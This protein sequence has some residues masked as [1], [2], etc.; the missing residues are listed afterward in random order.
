MTQNSRT[1]KKASSP[2]A[3]A[4]E[5]DKKLGRLGHVASFILVNGLVVAVIAFIVLH[6]LMQSLAQEEARNM[7]RDIL[8]ATEQSLSENEKTVHSLEYLYA[9]INPGNEEE[10][11]ALTDRVQKLLT[12][13]SAI[14]GVLW[15]TDRGIWRQENVRG[16]AAHRTSY[17][18][19]YGWPDFPSLNKQ[20]GEAPDNQITY[21]QD[22]PWP[23]MQGKVTSAANTPVGLAIRSHLQDGSIGILLVVTTP[24]KIFGNAWTIQREDIASVMIQDRDTGFILVN[25]LLGKEAPPADGAAP[26]PAPQAEEDS[27]LLSALG[28]GNAPEKVNY[29][30]QLGDQF[31]NIAFGVRPTTVSRFLGMAPLVAA[32]LI[33]LLTA[34][35]AIVAQRKYRQ[36]MML[37]EMSK[38]L[39]GAHSELQSRISERDKLFHALRKSEREYRAVINSVSDV[40]FETDETGRL[41]F[42]NET[43][44]KMTHR[45]VAETIGQSL[46]A[47]FEQGE[48]N[49][50]R[51][52]FE[53]LVRGERQAY[54]SETQLNLG[55]GSLKPV[56]VAFSMLRMTEDKS[57]R[58]V[59]TITDIEKRRRAEQAVRAA[60]QRYR[61]IF[62]NSVSGL[63]QID[64]EGR[65]ISA[66]YALAEV[67]GYGSPDELIANVTDIGGQI[68]ANR[69][70]H[71]D[72]VQRLLFEGRVSGNEVE[73]T[74]RDGARR[75]VLQNARTVRN[76]TGK[77]DYYEGSLWDVT[78]RREADE[79][80]RNARIQAEISSRTRMEFLANMSHE[81]RTPL[82]AVIGF[83]E[84]IKDEVMGPLEIQVYKE[85]AQDIYDSGNY[86]LKIISE[87]LEVS[88]IETGNR[89][90]NIS[91]FRLEKALKSCVTIMNSRIE[92][93]GVELK[94][95]IPQE[96]PEL[97]AEELGIKQVMLNLIGNAIKFTPEGGHVKVSAGLNDDGGMTIDIVDDGIGMSEEEIKKAMQ[98]FGKVDTT[99]SGM[100]EGTGLGLTIVESLVRLH[101]GQF[102]IISQKG[103]GT[104]AR[105]ILPA[106][107]LLRDEGPPEVSTL[108]TAEDAPEGE[109]S[110]DPERGAADPLAA[111][112]TSGT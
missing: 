101:G 80:M 47:M 106:S 79:A 4:A 65:F 36:D 56:E 49:K 53:E 39:E 70:D 100:K 73:I 78:E 86:L 95:D 35:S 2:Q 17:D 67:L 103:L 41:M 107:R 26:V 34:L 71:K 7:T 37:A 88:K 46:F 109:E 27:P 3:I 1:P 62:E 59:G 63:Y 58:V 84:I 20:M 33:L 81:L 66:N 97:Q 94:I 87:I 111:A 44:K 85:Y 11:L 105:V 45:E 60:E 21:L 32:A 112:S 42:L 30:L 96:L 64:A 6:F 10:T 61:T 13:G 52:M 89:D 69:E 93:S 98:P 57:L 9:T 108:Y 68:Y 104:T 18:A 24:S 75:W 51:E 77:V 102:Q 40:I 83:S 16:M 22:L 5:V 54:R 15:V 90:L 38:N 25:A 12:G 91:N 23:A 76:E 72:F 31:W 50:Q 8:R 55:Q 48:Q 43:W 99:F 28:M 14:S 74:R 92:Q 29:V 19:S 110:T 82:N